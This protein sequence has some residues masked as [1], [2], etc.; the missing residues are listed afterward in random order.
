MILDIKS[1]LDPRVTQKE[2]P[3]FGSSS[4]M[5]NV[6]GKLMVDNDYSWERM[7]FSIP[8]NDA[9]IISE[10]AV[11]MLCPT[12]IHQAVLHPYHA[13]VVQGYT[14]L[15]ATAVLK[16]LETAANFERDTE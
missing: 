4:Q 10:H 14:D 6:R 9:R 16:A 5:Y 13:A 7:N 2:I 8:L 15:D 1:G 11:K 3:D 12:P